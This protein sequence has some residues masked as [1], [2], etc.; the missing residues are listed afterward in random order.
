MTVALLTIGRGTLRD[1]KWLIAFL[2]KARG[3]G[4]KPARPCYFC[5]AAVLV[6]GPFLA[7]CEVLLTLTTELFQCDKHKIPVTTVSQGRTDLLS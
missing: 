7:V 6:L 3:A 2:Q 5:P 1:K 4:K